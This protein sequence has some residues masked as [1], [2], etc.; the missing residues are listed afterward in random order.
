MTS[1]WRPTPDALPGGHPA[2]EL[3]RAS[4]AAWHLSMALLA[5]RDGPTD[6]LIIGVR[7]ALAEAILI[8]VLAAQMA[9]TIKTETAQRPEVP[10]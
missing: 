7:D 8:T 6:D 9:E 5:C 4:Y 2:A 3:M 10:G 1:D